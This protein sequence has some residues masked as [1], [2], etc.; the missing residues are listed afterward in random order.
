MDSFPW[1]K[2]AEV[3][4]LPIEGGGLQLGFVDRAARAR[5][6]PRETQA[7]LKWSEIDNSLGDRM[8]ELI[9]G[10]FAHPAGRENGP[11]ET[12]PLDEWVPLVSGRDARFYFETDDLAILMNTAPMRAQNPLLVLTPMGSQCWRDILAGRQVAELRSESRRVFGKDAVIPFL[13]RLHDQGFL[14]PPPGGFP[15]IATG[16]PVGPLEFHAPEIQH[17]LPRARVPWYVLWE[18]TR[19]CNLRCRTCYLPDFATPGPDAELASQ[20]VR[21]M[22]ELGVFYVGILGGEPLL[23]PDLGNIISQLRLQGSFVKII[24]NGTLLTAE[25]AEDLV[26]SGINQVEVSFDGLTAASHDRSRGRGTFDGAI[27]AVRNA[28]AAGAPRVAAVLTLHRDNLAELPELPAFLKS[29]GIGECYI[30]RFRRT[31]LNGG[32]S[33]FASLN[34][35]QIQSVIEQLEAWKLTHHEMTLS[36]GGY[37]RCSCGRTSLVVGA[38]NDIRACTFI[39]EGS[40]D[41]SRTSLSEAWAAVSGHGAG[42]TPPG[43]CHESFRIPT[44][45]TSDSA[46]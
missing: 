5:L 46:R 44:S 20:I 15:P 24:T 25:R 9:R 19:S 11:L 38:G 45:P 35:D 27:K 22:G 37:P 2:S 3:L 36:L 13:H 6:S 1:I 8:E 42:S 10:G 40:G 30:S 28:Q 23:R 39:R 34:E 14:H 43:F 26:S 4:T 12:H 41:L 16:L 33:G 21:Q 31:G 18:I 17:L 7:W 29:L 32:A